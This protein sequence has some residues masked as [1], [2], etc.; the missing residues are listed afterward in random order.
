[1]PRYFRKRA[2]DKTLD[3]IGSGLGNSVVDER[4]RE[5][6]V[7]GYLISRLRTLGKDC[8]QAISVLLGSYGF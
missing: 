2:S 3:E 7:L 5:A 6:G 1:V 8:V 4:C